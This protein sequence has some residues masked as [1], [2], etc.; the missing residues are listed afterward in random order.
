MLRQVRM[1]VAAV[2]A[3]LPG[4]LAAQTATDTIPE[5]VVARSYEAIN[6]SDAAAYYSLFAPVWYHS[7]MEDSTKAPH[8]HTR[9]E[10]I[11]SAMFPQPARLRFKPVN[12]IVMGPYVVDEQLVVDLGKVHLDIFQVRNGQIVHEWESDLWQPPA[13]SKRGD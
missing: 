2:L 9:G 13:S 7:T 11:D 8:R 4:G 12:R 10:K 6:R 5:Q 3:I 1:L